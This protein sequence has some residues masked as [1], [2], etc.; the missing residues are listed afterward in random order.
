MEGGG[1]RVQP[2]PFVKTDILFI[3]KLIT[4]KDFSKSLNKMFEKKYLVSLC[5]FGG[6]LPLSCHKIQDL[7]YCV[8]ITYSVPVFNNLVHCIVLQ[9][10]A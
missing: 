8:S 3:N 1:E 2:G 7:H 10:K 9:D 4:Y 5:F 6:C